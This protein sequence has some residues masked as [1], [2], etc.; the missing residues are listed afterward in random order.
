MSFAKSAWAGTVERVARASTSARARWPARVVALAPVLG[1]L[2]AA[3]DRRWMDE[4]GFI[5]LR[6]VRNVLHGAGPVFNL[7]ERVEAATSPAWIAVLALLGALRLRLEYAAVF[8]GI[9]LTCAGLVLAQDA[10][11][12]LRG[13]RGLSWRERWATPA[14]PLGAAIV[15]VLPPTWDYASSGLETGLSLAWLGASFRVVAGRATRPPST[16]GQG[17]LQAVL[18]GAGPLVRPEFALY[19]AA[20]LVPYAAAVARDRAGLL[21]R[22]RAVVAA[23]LCA[24]ALPLAYQLFRMGYYA[25]ITPNTAIAKEAFMANL[26]QGRCYFDNFF[27]TYR[28]AVPLAAAGAFWAT[29]LR[30]DA[31]ARRWLVVACAI[32]PVVAGAVHVGY[33]VVMGGDYMH[34]RLLVPPVF[35]GLLPVMTIPAPAPRASREAVPLTIAGAAAIA[36][37]VVCGTSLR[38]GVENVC[39]VGD[40]RGWYARKAEVPN[41]VLVGSFRKHFFYESSQKWLRRIRSDCGGEAPVDSSAPGCRQVYLDDDK[42]QIAPAPEASPLDPSVAPEVLGVVSVGAIGV[43]GYVLPDRVHVVDYNGLSDAIVGRF[44]LPTRGRPGHEKTLPAAWLLGRYAKPADGE[45]SA[46]TAA[47]HALHC[48]ALAELERDV[49]RPLTAAGFLH[50]VAHA[51]ENARLRIP[52]DPFEA[53]ERFCGSP[54]RPEVTV[55]GKGGTAFRWLCPAGH[56]LS[57]FRVSYK[58][59]EKALARVLALCGTGGDSGEAIAGPWFG[60]S[61]DTSLEMACPPEAVVTG[62]YGTSDDLVRTVGAVCRLRAGADEAAAPPKTLQTSTGGVSGGRSYAR[63]CPPRTV[64]IGIVGHAGSLV[65]SLGLVCGG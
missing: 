39:N 25:S 42:A 29:R 41:P 35:A 59:N 45:D 16:A 54:R 62:F 55:G 27:V 37:V 4:D 18:L 47:R 49:G 60:E 5:N 53:E 26:S 23:G 65:D 11:L 46:V 8:G 50:N 30:D 1:L 13:P 17:A 9:A 28:M 56:T 14:L 31:S 7:D 6:I 63:T 58:P 20:F 61:A 24:A 36:W 32:A 33:L 12:V 19:S 22:V 52:R 2:A 43:V 64:A 40:E 15:A 51:W 21:R 57:G 44:E 10:A 34:G 38:V 48:G 3:I